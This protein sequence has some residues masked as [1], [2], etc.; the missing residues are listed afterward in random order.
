MKYLHLGLS[1]LD[2]D[3]VGRKETRFYRLFSEGNGE[4]DRR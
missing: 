4:M 3:I 2:E 1:S